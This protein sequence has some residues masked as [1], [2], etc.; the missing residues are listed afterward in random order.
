MKRLGIILIF[1]LMPCLAQAEMYF[2]EKVVDARTLVLLTGEHVHLMGV[3]IPE[4]RPDGSVATNNKEKASE[5][6][7]SLVSGSKV[8]LQFAE[9]VDEEGYRQAYAWFLYPEENVMEALEFKD[10]YRMNEIV[11]DWGEHR[12]VAF[13][14]AVIIKAGY[15]TPKEHLDNSEY[16]SLMVSLYKPGNIQALNTVP[17]AAPAALPVVASK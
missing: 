10:D 3:N 12:Y 15:G 1:L 17:L 7:R 11:E 2:I 5:Y 14:N 6:V 4:N 16:A 8:D 13:L 9:G